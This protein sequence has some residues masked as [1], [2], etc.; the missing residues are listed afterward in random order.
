[1]PCLMTNKHSRL[2]NLDISFIFL[3]LEVVARETTT[4]S[5]AKKEVGA[6][7]LAAKLGT[8]TLENKEAKM[9][10]ATFA[11]EEAKHVVK[12]TRSEAASMGGSFLEALTS[13]ECY[14]NTKVV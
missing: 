9:E 7:E 8:V 5:A 12:S 3:Q 14:K 2:N 1:M 4:D 11:D 13:S 10:G 6:D